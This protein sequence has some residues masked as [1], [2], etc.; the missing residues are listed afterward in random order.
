MHERFGRNVDW[1][2]EAQLGAGTEAVLD[3]LAVELA[4]EGVRKGNLFGKPCLKLDSKAFLC[5]F[6]DSMVF[7][8][9]GQKFEHA[10]SLTGATLFDPSGAKRPMKQWVQ[11][12]DDHAREWRALA[13]DALAY[14]QLAKK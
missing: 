12:P 6:G 9:G 1:R 3:E 2:E 14:S 10:I 11:V 4:G 5:A 13:R 7:K 8:L